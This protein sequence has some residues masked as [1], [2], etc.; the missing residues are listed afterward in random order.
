M[1]IE[2]ILVV[3][4]GV[5]LFIV[6]LFP[7]LPDMDFLSTSFQPLVNVMAT[8]NSFVSVSLFAGCCVAFIV[9]MNIDFIWSIIMW[10]VRKI[11][12]VT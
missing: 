10:V 4:K 8:I 5:I 11:P 12:G 2:G 7:T 3:V 1:I 9:F 6:N